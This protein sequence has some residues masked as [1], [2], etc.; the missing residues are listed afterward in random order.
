MQTLD[1]R[2]NPGQGATLGSKRPQAE[3]NPKQETTL[4]SMQP[5]QGE[6]LGMGQL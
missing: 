3:G 4:N 2:Q 6:T 5:K 1:R